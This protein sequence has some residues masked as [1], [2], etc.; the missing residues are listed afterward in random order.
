MKF[1]YIILGFAILIASVLNK[2]LT[3]SHQI[4]LTGM[5]IIF[6]VAG[7]GYAVMDKIKK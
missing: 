2:E 4:F 5:A 1:L 6:V 3:I 7:M